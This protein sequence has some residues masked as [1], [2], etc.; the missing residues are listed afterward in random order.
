MS[1]PTKLT[2]K[3]RVKPIVTE[4][5]KPK[6]TKRDKI[7]E[8]IIISGND[9]V[10]TKIYEYRRHAQVVKDIIWNIRNRYRSKK[11]QPMKNKSLSLY[12][13]IGC[14]ERTMISHLK[15]HLA[16]LSYDNNLWFKYHIKWGLSFPQLE[17]QYP[18]SLKKNMFRYNF[19]LPDIYAY[20][21]HH[22]PAYKNRDEELHKIFL[23]HYRS[24]RNVPMIDLTDAK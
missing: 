23:A 22:S 6:L 1:G 10:D 11:I 5:T 8:R 4:N 14:D 7:I 24:W 19:I 18:T 21:L 12:D 2:F 9:L 13:L 20:S 15:Q 17:D 16:D 3:P